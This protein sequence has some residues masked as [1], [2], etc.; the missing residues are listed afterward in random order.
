MTSPSPFPPS[1]TWS[2][3]MRRT[4]ALSLLLGGL[5]FL[6]FVRDVLPLI[7]VSSLIAYIL[8]PMVHVLAERVLVFPFMGAGVRRGCGALIAFLFV[9]FLITIGLLVIVPLLLSQLEEFGRSI[10]RL[11]TSIERDLER[12]LSQPLALSG[13]IVLLEGEPIIPLERLAEALGVASPR[14]VIQLSSLDLTVATEAFLGSLGSLTGSAFGFLGGAFTTVINLTFLLM[15]TFYM[16]KDGEVFLDYI[17]RIA[18]PGYEGDAQR[19]SRELG[20]V[21]NAYVRGQL[22]LCVVMG[23]AVYFAA[24]LLGLPNAPIL[25][26][27]AGVFEFIPTLGP[28]LALIPAAFLALVSQSTTLPF[29]EGVPFML[30][31]IV[32]WTGLQNIEAIFLVPR[33]MGDS[34]DLHPYVVIVGVLG[35]AAL[36]GAIGVILAAPFIA[37]G[38][39]V[40]RYVYG[41]TTGRS[42]FIAYQENAPPRLPWLS[43]LLAPGIRA[44]Y[45]RL[46]P[47]WRER[48]RASG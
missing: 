18:P 43:Q 2:P 7:I 26:L 42:P 28:L 24:L 12:I 45:R 39:I 16:L 19:L 5:V 29:L 21:W 4:V 6:W 47:R 10:P 36:A 44:L 23:F 11:L 13:E 27:L 33:V 48:L 14:E 25:G 32:V 20:K 30:T 37:S 1:P 17:L 34:L 8:H 31:V 38:R 40:T 35:G 22:I 3:R 15:L 9:F 46:P 41:K